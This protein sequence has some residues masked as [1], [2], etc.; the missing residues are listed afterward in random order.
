MEDLHYG[1]GRLAVASGDVELEVSFATTFILDPKGGDAFVWTTDDDSWVEA[2]L[3]IEGGRTV[4]SLRD[5]I[6]HVQVEEY[7]RKLMHGACV[8]SITEEY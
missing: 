5:D 8:K 6:D 4:L 1:S 2:N 7:H 3:M